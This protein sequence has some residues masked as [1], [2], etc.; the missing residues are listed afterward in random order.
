M[1]G[2]VT[3]SA[4]CSCSAGGP[5][6]RAGRPRCLIPR[7]PQV[8]IRALPPAP[9]PPARPPAPRSCAAR[10]GY[11]PGPR[12]CDGDCGTKLNLLTQR[13]RCPVSGQACP[14]APIAQRAHACGTGQ[15]DRVSSRAKN[16]HL[17]PP[18]RPSAALAHGCACPRT[19]AH[20]TARRTRR[21][22]ARHA[23]RMY[24]R[25][26]P[27]PCANAP[28][29]LIAFFLFMGVIGGTKTAVMSGPPPAA[30]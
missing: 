26:A 8:R 20:G 2:S 19:T 27:T 7:P 29:T 28:I 25:C 22:A 10:A 17:L 18:V 11:A 4:R 30:Y 3:M 14:C 6:R 1:A 5:R 23:A 13:G 9:P 16:G 24:A 21:R 15:A 12:S